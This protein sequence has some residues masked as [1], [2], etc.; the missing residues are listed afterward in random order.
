MKTS[1]SLAIEVMRLLQLAAHRAPAVAA[2][3][4]TVHTDVAYYLLNKRRE[5]A[6]LEERAKMEVQVN[7]PVGR[8]AGHPGRSA[9]STTTATRCGCSR[10]PPPRMFRGGDWRPRP[11]RRRPARRTD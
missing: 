5:I 1:E 6:A 11:R 7:G 9:A 8:V 10:A 2:V 4:L 3:Q